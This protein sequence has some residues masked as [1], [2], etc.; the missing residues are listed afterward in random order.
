MESWNSFLLEDQ[1][2]LITKLINSG[3]EQQKAAAKVLVQD[4]EVMQAAR[5]LKAI[6][7]KEG[8]EEGIL[9]DKVLQT[10]ISGTN[11]LKDFFETPMGEAARILK[12]IAEKEGIE[13]G[14]L[15][16]KVLQTYISGTNKLKDFF[17]TP[18]GQKLKQYGGPVLAMAA[19]T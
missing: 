2:D 13:E 5:I 4:P 9:A 10:Y 15:A 12:A 19:K 7:E 18:M 3:P 1:K 11:K 17:E 14:I 8:I 16:D 6:A